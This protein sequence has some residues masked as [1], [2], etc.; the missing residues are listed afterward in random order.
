MWYY[1]LVNPGVQPGEAKIAVVVILVQQGETK[2]AVVV[3]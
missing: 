2:I 3:M 1:S